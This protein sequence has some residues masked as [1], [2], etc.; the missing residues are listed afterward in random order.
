MADGPQAPTLSDGPV[1]SP[2][3]AF[4]SSASSTVGA[5]LAAQT[6]PP[7]QNPRIGDSDEVERG[8][9]ASMI[10]ALSE[11]TTSSTLAATRLPDDES[12][13][14]SAICER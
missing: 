6:S 2:P 13:S 7:G 11:I 1:A 4:L 12:T 8:A 3:C 14:L 5:E 10:E 9:G